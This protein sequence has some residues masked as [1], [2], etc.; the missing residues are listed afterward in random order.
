M[1]CETYIAL[2]RG[3]N[4][5]GKHILPMK[6]LV[7][8][9]ADCKCR[10]V[11]TYIQSG[12]LI[13]AA[14]GDVARSFPQK[15]AKKIQERFG[16]ASPVIVRTPDE[17]AQIVRDNP[18][19]KAGKPEK[20]L[21][22]HFLA[23]LPTAEAIKSLDPD[24]SPPDA[25]RVVGRNVYLHTPNGMGRTKLTSTYL[26]SRLGTVGTARNWATVKKL[27]ELATSN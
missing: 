4:V 23:E 1:A 19:L 8:L 15:L 21:H 17:L 22:V 9:A 5:G 10:E 11:R 13:F 25:F 24:R 18:F 26:D 16:F 7:A 6:D 14:P 27:L 2:L 3:V 12:N 20:E